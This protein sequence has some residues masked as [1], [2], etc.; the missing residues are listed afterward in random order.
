MGSMQ[1]NF[2]LEELEETYN[3]SIY[4]LTVTHGGYTQ[5]GVRVHVVK[6]LDTQKIIGNVICLPY[7]KLFEYEVME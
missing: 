6:E 5:D 3:W 2:Q 4:G 7:S 1:I